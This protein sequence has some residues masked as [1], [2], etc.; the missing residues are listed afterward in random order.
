MSHARNGL[1]MRIW[2]MR[3]KVRRLTEHVTP[4]QRQ[5]RWMILIC[6]TPRPIFGG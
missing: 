1:D 6:N 5:I 2:R 3:K 4:N